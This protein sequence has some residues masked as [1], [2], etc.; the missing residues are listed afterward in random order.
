MFVWNVLH[1]NVLHWDSNIDFM[2]VLATFRLKYSNILSQYLHPESFKLT[3]K[4]G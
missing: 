3:R 1:M 2:T 4:E